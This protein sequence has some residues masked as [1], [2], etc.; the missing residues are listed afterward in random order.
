MY[1]NTP[2]INCSIKKKEDADLAILYI[3]RVA[4]KRWI[5]AEAHFWLPKNLGNIVC[6]LM[7]TSN[8][9]WTVSEK[10]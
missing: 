8:S 7:T 3:S 5:E 6:C 10:F 4:I 2:V 1:L 9:K